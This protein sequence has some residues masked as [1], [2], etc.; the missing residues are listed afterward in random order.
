[1]THVLRWVLGL[2]SAGRLGGEPWKLEGAREVAN[3]EKEMVKQPPEESVN[4]LAH[5]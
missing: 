2:S 1:M 4:S 3:R 5:C